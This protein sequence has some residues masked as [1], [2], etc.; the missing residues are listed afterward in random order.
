M[1]APTPQTKKGKSTFLHEGSFGCAYTPPVAC[2]K[3]K[4]R[5][6]KFVGK[7]LPKSDVTVELSL[8]ALI[9]SIPS[10]ED[11]YIVPE[12]E[13]CDTRDFFLARD[14]Y[15]GDC[16]LFQRVK[17]K[18]LA[19]LVS[20]YGGT[21][22]A[23]LTYASDFKYIESF[24]HLL[25]GVAQLHE[26]GI[27]H[28]DLHM[29]NVLSDYKGTFRII[30]FGI[31]FLVPNLTNA[32]I[33]QRQVEF[34]PGYAVEAPDLTIQRAIFDNLP[35]DKALTMLIQEKKVLHYAASVL[36][37]SLDEQK[38][39]LRRFC[40]ED[41]SMRE[42]NWLLFYKTYAFKWD[43][44]CVGMLFMY[45]LND[46]LLQTWFI[47]SVWQTERQKIRAAL[48]AL[49]RTDPRQRATAK[50]VLDFLNGAE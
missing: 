11:Y 8:N 46:L 7:I 45:I 29:A 26:K 28:F 37:L 5:K 6:G 27:C 36:G 38:E 2:K 22:I 41:H 25:R 12:I 23:K 3:K 48:R 4:Q 16:K 40:Y 1:S 32:M 18:D 39:S 9:R 33:E 47:Q 19:Q 13:S 50:Q 14:S 34:S 43:S 30:D 20:P 49:L 31:S 24:K 44:W 10:Y 42:K 15:A 35:L 17:D 21:A